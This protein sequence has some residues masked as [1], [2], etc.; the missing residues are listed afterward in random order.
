MLIRKS[1]ARYRNPKGSVKPLPYNNLTWHL[2]GP[3]SGYGLELSQMGLSPP[4]SLINDLKAD[5]KSRGDS[6]TTMFEDIAELRQSLRT[7]MDTVQ[8]AASAHNTWNWLRTNR[9]AVPNAWL[10]YIFGWVP[11]AGAA[12]RL[13]TEAQKDVQTWN[14]ERASRHA[15]ETEKLV[16]GDYTGTVTVR[17]EVKGGFK[18]RPRK[19][20]KNFVRA[21]LSNP[22]YN[23]WQVVGWSWAVD[24]FVDL[25]SMFKNLERFDEQF[26]MKDQWFAV[27]REIIQIDATY[28]HYVGKGRKST[29]KVRLVK[30]FR[31][32]RSQSIPPYQLDMKGLKK[33]SQYANLFS[34]MIQAKDW[35]DVRDAE[36]PHLKQRIKLAQGY[37]NLLNDKTRLQSAVANRTKWE[38][39]YA[40]RKQE[41]AEFNRYRNYWRKVK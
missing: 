35:K 14:T 39:A 27:Y 12:K 2:E 40:Q 11:I 21:G 33:A 37:V 15:I 4:P 26:E 16:V 28:K 29:E 32:S 20:N 25:S 8:G 38:V 36:D 18:Y 7:V 6:Y 31:F 41:V 9:R 30:A 19:V 24:Y 1:K 5:L 3:G 13:L 34:A 22:V 10:T 23:V 17:Y